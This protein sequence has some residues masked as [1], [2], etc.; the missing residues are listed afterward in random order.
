MPHPIL[1]VDDS[2]SIRMLMRT[3]LEREHYQV[4][5]AVDGQDALTKLDGQPLALILSDIIISVAPGFTSRS[6]SSQSVASAT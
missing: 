4:L 6:V 2:P 5:E 3:V 1:L